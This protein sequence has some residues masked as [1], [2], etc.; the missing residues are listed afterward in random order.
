MSA[1]LSP[2]VGPRG[3][4]LLCGGRWLGAG[5]GLRGRGLGLE[6]GNLRDA[7]T[8]SGLLLGRR[9]LAE[10]R[11]AL[12]RRAPDEFGHFAFYRDLLVRFDRSLIGLPPHVGDFAIDVPRRFG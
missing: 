11:L 1:E 2:G 8:D 12:E 7:H 5:P 3:R 6:A 4:G 10:L 9:H